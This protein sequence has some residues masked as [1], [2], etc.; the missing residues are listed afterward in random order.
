VLRSDF[1]DPDVF[2]AGDTYYA[3]ATNGSGHNVQVASSADLVSWTLMGDGMPTLP[4]WAALGG[5]SVWAPDVIQIGNTYVLYYTARDQKSNKQCVGVATATKPEGHYKDTSDKALVCPA[6]QG[7]AIDASAFQ[8]GGNLYLYWKND[9]NC[10]GLPTNLYVQQLSPDGLSLVSPP[11]KLVTN[12]QVWEG[13]VVEAP[14]MWKHAD[15]YY[16]FFS[17]N[18]YATDKYA[19]GYATCKSPAGPCQEA[20]ENPVLK[21]SLQNPPVIGPGGESLIQVGDQT[22]M[23]YHAWEVSGGNLTQRRLMWLDKLNWTD[24][25]PVVMGPTTGPQAKP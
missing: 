21:S 3:Y 12:D 4:S 10:C 2:K 23:I 1:A 22:W 17:G 11:V 20:Q 24:G 18:K 7:G 16:L 8:D 9:G 6:D 14:F 25:K 5:S 13:S 19:V 15:S